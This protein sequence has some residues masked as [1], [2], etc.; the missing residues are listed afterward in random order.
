MLLG[1][2]GEGRMGAGLGKPM[3]AG[4]GGSEPGDGRSQRRW[5]HTGQL[6]AAGFLNWFELEMSCENPSTSCISS[7]SSSSCFGHVV[8]GHLVLFPHLCEICVEI[9]YEKREEGGANLIRMEFFFFLLR[10]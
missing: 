1:G 10:L 4:D 6:Q 5:G 3:G 7:E 2:A 9:L 8:F